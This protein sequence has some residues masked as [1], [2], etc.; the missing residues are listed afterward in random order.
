MV[1]TTNAE[2]GG[3]LQSEIIVAPVAD[4]RPQLLEPDATAPRRHDLS[5]RLGMDSKHQR[6]ARPDNV[7]LVDGVNGND[8]WMSQAVWDSVMA[9]GDSGH[10]HLHRRHR[11][12]QDRG[13][14]TRRI[15]L[16]ARRHRQRRHQVRHQHHHGTA[17]AYGRDGSCDSRNFF[18]SN[19]PASQIPPLASSSLAPPSAGPSRRTSSSTS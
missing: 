12:I 15:W 4:E 3:T 11:R 13:K 6:H 8:P 16:E 2:L 14:S 17:F 1:E 10:A 9:S 18:F 7:Y 5:R 19:V